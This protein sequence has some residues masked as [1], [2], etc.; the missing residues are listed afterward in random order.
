MLRFCSFSSHVQ[1][2]LKFTAPSTARRGQPN[3]GFQRSIRWCGAW[4]DAQRDQVR[5]PR[6]PGLSPF[7]AKIVFAQVEVDEGRRG[8]QKHRND[9]A[10]NETWPFPNPVWKFF[11]TKRCWYENQD[12]HP[13]S[14][15]K[16]RREKTQIRQ[17]KGLRYGSRN[18]SVQLIS[19]NLPQFPKWLRQ[20]IIEDPSTEALS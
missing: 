8:L 10:K 17:L 3:W 7:V 9:L 12:G 16:I 15:K 1:T 11:W 6:I 13:V 5:P 20:C 4:P 2:H 14:T 19:K 18:N